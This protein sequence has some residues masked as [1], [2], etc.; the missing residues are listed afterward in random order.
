MI[1]APTPQR[2]SR[3]FA[4]SRTAL[5][6]ASNRAPPS[7][8]PAFSPESSR[9]LFRAF[10]LRSFPFEPGD[11]LS[12]DASF[13]EVVVE[14]VED[15][16]EDAPRA[17]DVAEDDAP[18]PGDPASVPVFAFCASVSSANFAS[19]SARSKQE[20]VST[21]AFTS[22]RF[23]SPAETRSPPPAAADRRAPRRSRTRAETA[24]EDREG[25]RGA[26][27][28]LGPERAARRVARP[29]TAPRVVPAARL[30]IVVIADPA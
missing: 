25:R 11:A 13:E 10:P 29:R 30:A 8:P 15:V 18:S 26:R 7:K 22:A 21:P 27:D 2:T 16:E 20:E 3:R 14:E 12:L 9:G 24:R 28:A 19:R 23:M 4:V 17:D 1:F 5:S 6:A